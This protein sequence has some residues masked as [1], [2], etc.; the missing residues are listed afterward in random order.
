MGG[1][2]EGEKETGEL[3]GGAVERAPAVA[4][5]DIAAMGDPVGH[6][7]ERPAVLPQLPRDS[8]GPDLPLDGA[9]RHRELALLEGDCDD[10]V[11]EGRPAPIGRQRVEQAE[12]VLAP[13]HA[14]RHPIPPPPHAATPRPPGRSMEKRPMAR[15]M[16]S[17]TRRSTSPGP[18]TLSRRPRSRQDAEEPRRRRP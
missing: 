9:D 4:A 12:A 18:M 1:V 5:A 10:V 7:P 15:P 16:A 3:G 11:G 2:A 17:S 13:G 14:D 6:E 8:D